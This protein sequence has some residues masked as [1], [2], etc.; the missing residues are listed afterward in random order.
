MRFEP[1]RYPGDRRLGGELSPALGETLSAPRLFARKHEAAETIEPEIK[2]QDSILNPQQNMNETLKIFPAGEL[3]LVMTRSFDAPCELVF[4]AFTKPE[5]VKQWLL[6]PDGWSMP[7]CEID[8]KVGGKY[9]YVWQR[10]SDGHEMG[11]GGVFR[12]ID[13][14]RRIVH[15]EKF[16]EAWYS[17]EAV[18]T[19]KFDPEEGKTNVTTTIRYESREARDG[20]LE[21]GMESGVSVSYDRLDR[22]LASMNR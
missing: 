14:P 3:E 10:D 2:H 11:M 1:R 12:E 16:D 15:T 5:L 7:V 17:G 22:V 6:G 18:I 13:R 20:V 8:P 19:T 4:D 21:S 9:R